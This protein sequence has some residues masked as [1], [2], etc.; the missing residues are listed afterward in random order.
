MFKHLESSARLP[1]AWWRC[2]GRGSQGGDH[3][4]LIGQG[5]EFG[6]YPDRYGKLPECF[7]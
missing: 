3:A 7:K 2:S 4:E 1:G 6:F 5:Q